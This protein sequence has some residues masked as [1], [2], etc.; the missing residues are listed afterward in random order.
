[1]I[2]RTYILLFVLFVLNGCSEPLYTSIDNN[3]LKSLMAEGIPLY[4]IRR[5]DEWQETGVIKGSRLL[6]FLDTH[7]RPITNF[8]PNFSKEVEKNDPVILICRSGVRSAA[9]SRHLTE[10]M[11]Y[12]EVYNARKGIVRWIREKNLVVRQ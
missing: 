12:S 3:H 7:G 2:A 4:D 9:L 11:G 10:K 6:T 8:F 5:Q 1:M